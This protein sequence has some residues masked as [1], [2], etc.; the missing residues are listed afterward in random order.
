MARWALLLLA[1]I[2]LAS[3]RGEAAEDGQNREYPALWGRG[4]SGRPAACHR[5]N[6]RLAGSSAES[7]YER[8]NAKAN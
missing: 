7:N 6:W 3:C 8:D 4:G 1:S 5:H 2:A